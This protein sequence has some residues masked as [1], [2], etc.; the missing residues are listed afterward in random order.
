MANHNDTGKK[1]EDIAKQYLEKNGYT[2]RHTNWRTG[3]Y[4]VDIIAEK[5]NWLI[6]AEVKTRSANFW[7]NPIET[8]NKKKKTNLIKAARTYVVLNNWQG[9]NRFDIIGI[10]FDKNNYN[11]EHIEGAFFPTMNGL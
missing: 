5:E 2:V 9:N 3:R 8:I 6:F 11:I 1:G 7:V 4:E 10:V